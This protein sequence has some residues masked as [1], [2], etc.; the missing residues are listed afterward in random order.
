MFLKSKSRIDRT[1][2]QIKWSGMEGRQ[3]PLEQ[4][5]LFAGPAFGSVIE[6]E[7][8]PLFKAAVYTDLNHAIYFLM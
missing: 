6:T 2:I 8:F 7:S 1:L 3:S 5:R 4:W